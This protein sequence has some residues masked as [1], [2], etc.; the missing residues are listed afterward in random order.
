MR[1]TMGLS[2]ELAM[3][4]MITS[5]EGPVQGPDGRIGVRGVTSDGGDFHVV[6][7]QPAGLHNRAEHECVL[8]R[9]ERLTG[10]LRGLYGM[11]P[12]R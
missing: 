1:L 2:Q 3:K 4:P 7:T 9:A 6:V 11:A 8:T 12:A 5:W 10:V